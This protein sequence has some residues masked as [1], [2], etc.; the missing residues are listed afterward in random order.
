MLPERTRRRARRRARWPRSPRYERTYGVREVDAYDYPGA[1]VGLQP[2]VYAGSLDGAAA[3]VTPAGRAAGFGYLRGGL[4][5]RRRRPRRL[6]GLRLPGDA[7][8]PRRP[9]SDLHPAVTA[10]VG[11]RTGVLAGVHAAA[12]RERLVL[13]AAYNSSMQ[14]FARAR[15]PGWSAG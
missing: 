2:P 15:R 5:D 9:A 13:T 12:G 1:D 8:R 11:G 6:R 14:W 4:T 7:P 3:T 10:T